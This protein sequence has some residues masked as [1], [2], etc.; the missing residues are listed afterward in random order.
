M[1]G[2]VVIIPYPDRSC[3]TLTF[4]GWTGVKT[5]QV[6]RKIEGE[7]YQPVRSGLDFDLDVDAG[8]NPVGTGTLDDYEA[9]MD[10]DL[11]Y[12]IIQIDPT[13][14]DDP[15]VL[16]GYVL[17]SDGWSWLKDPALPFRN[18]RLEEVTTIEAETFTSRAGIFDVIDR[19]RPV[20]VA[21]RRQDR[22]TQLDLTTATE[23]Q[24]LSMVSLLST[25]QVLLL[26]TPGAYGWGNEYV[27]IGDV[28]ETRIGLAVEP[29]RRWTLPVAVVDRP[30]SL[31]YQPAVMTWAD[32]VSDWAT[33]SDMIDE[34]ATWDS[35][36]HGVP[37]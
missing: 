2:A 18:V 36:I 11:T 4:S 31:S 13:T 27:H 25:G 9:P 19:S 15:L 12:R 28:T 33:W 21:A 22:T 26:T 24:R 5:V 14:T 10:V 17:D 29:S 20:V 37:E 3:V 6:D 32:V 34:N 8:G 35:L 16:P 23:A 7:K 1:A 30:I